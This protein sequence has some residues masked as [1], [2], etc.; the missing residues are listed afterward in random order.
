MR[1]LQSRRRRDEIDDIFGDDSSSERR[2]TQ[3]RTVGGT[4]SRP[5]NGRGDVRVH[6]VVPKTFNDAQDMADKYKDA[7]PVI[8]NLQGVEPT[9]PRLDRLRVRA[10][11]TRSTAACSASPTRS[12]CSRRATS[13]SRR[14]SARSWSRRAS[15][16]SPSAY[17][18]HAGRLHRIRQHGQRARSRLGRA[19]SLHRL[20]LRPGS[21][22]RFGARWRGRCSNRELAERAD[23]VILGHKPAQLSAVAH[24]IGDAA[25]GIVVSILGAPRS[26][27]S[28]PPT[29]RRPSSGSSRTRRS[30]CA[31]RARLRAVLPA[32]RG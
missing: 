10:S 7:I 1:R 11:P 16:T 19:R 22:A 32:G 3:L 26:P 24:E 17:S 14:S 6:L 5:A 18:A 30:R 4:A 25:D 20:G 23:L 21:A 15:S 12:S 28:R 27:R 31:G 13:R 9:S 2:T 8:I 29:Q